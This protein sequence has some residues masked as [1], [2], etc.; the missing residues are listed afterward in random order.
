MAESIAYRR[1]EGS[2]DINEPRFRPRFHLDRNAGLTQISGWRT[3]VG[4]RRFQH[5]PY[6]NVYDTGKSLHRVAF[7]N[8]PGRQRVCSELLHN[9][10]PLIRDI[11]R[12][13]ALFLALA[14]VDMGPYRE[15]LERVPFVP[16][17][18]EDLA[19]GLN[20]VY[21]NGL[22]GPNPTFAVEARMEARV[23]LDSARSHFTGW[24][25]GGTDAF[26]KEALVL[27][28]RRVYW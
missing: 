10:G 24:H 20:Q 28:P 3:E 1:S 9:P 14:G 12:R 19:E 16:D 13:L 23:R 22:R 27:V 11:N 26:W 5:I 8:G 6:L 21:L 25:G 17:Q 7:G 2:G 18:D 4:K 15:E